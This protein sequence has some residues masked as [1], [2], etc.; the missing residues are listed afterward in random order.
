MYSNLV[1][2]PD[3]VNNGLHSVT[4]V[5]PEQ[6]DVDAVVR[7]CQFSN[8]AFNVY[9]YTPN[10]DNNKWLSDAVNASDAIIINTRT[11]DYQDLCLL[12]KTYYYGPKNYVENQRKLSEPL[13]Y[14]ASHTEYDK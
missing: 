9:V 7:F 1:T 3:I 11:D 12:A 2:P 6:A 8:T 5:D 13:H 10:M 14:F 4:L